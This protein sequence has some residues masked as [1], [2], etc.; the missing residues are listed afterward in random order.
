MEQYVDYNFYKNTYKGDMPEEAFEKLIIKA[1]TEV[2][3]ATMNKNLK[4]HK[5]KVNFAIC[6]VIDILYKI[7]FIEKRKNNLISCE[8][9]DKV[10]ISEQVANVSR[11]YANSNNLKE[12]EQEINN[13]KSKISEE[14]EKYL[15]FTGLLYRG[16]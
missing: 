6:S 1:S 8:K 12:L 13:Q 4:E 2:Q 9:E 7:E 16:I 10:V 14:I 15:A 11:T 5:E 3:N